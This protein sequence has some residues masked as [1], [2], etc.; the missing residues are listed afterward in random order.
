M[1]T[2]S[3]SQDSYM[4]TGSP[5]QFRVRGQRGDWWV[6]GT[7]NNNV[8]VDAEQPGTRYRTKA[9]AQEAARSLAAQKQ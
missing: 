7:D 5:N 2:T 9:E 3:R 6:E 1:S 8:W 4:K